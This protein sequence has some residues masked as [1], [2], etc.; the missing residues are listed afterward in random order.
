[1]SSKEI[2]EKRTDKDKHVIVSVRR[3]GKKYMIVRLEGYIVVLFLCYLMLY[4]Y[5]DIYIYIYR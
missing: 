2:E 5:I 4:I 3:G 1:M